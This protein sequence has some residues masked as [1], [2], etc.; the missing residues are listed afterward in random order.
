MTAPIEGCYA[1]LVNSVCS[2]PSHPAPRVS[3]CRHREH[4]SES[5]SRRPWRHY[6][7]VTLIHDVIDTL[8]MCARA[9]VY[10]C[11]CEGVYISVFVSVFRIILYSHCHLTS[12]STSA[13]EISVPPDIFQTVFH[14]HHN[15]PIVFDKNSL[16]W[17]QPTNAQRRS[18]SATYQQH[19]RYKASVTWILCCQ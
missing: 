18:S 3:A 10:V 6:Q 4:H 12:F 5:L 19:T 8:C 2:L 13:T 1:S 15:A 11:V 17:Q 9:C 7:R 16:S 14:M